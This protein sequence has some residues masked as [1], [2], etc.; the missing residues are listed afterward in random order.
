ML[1]YG[2]LQSV[3]KSSWT[4]SYG[5]ASSRQ[6]LS[7]RFLTK[8][9]SNQTPQLQRLARKLKFTCSKFTYGTFQYNKD[10]DQTAQ[11]C[12]LVC[13]CVVRKPPKKGFLASQPIYWVYLKRSQ[14]LMKV[15]CESVSKSL[16]R[17]CRFDWLQYIYRSLF[18]C[19]I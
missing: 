6:N 19:L 16:T 14:T 13:T 11:M 18:V 8:R 9:V 4:R 17:Y 2:Q 3:C 1:F 10:T 12:R 15:G 7:S 5:P